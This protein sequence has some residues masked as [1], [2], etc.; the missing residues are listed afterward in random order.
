[1]YRGNVSL[2]DMGDVRTVLNTAIKAK[3]VVSKQKVRLWATEFSWD[4]KPPDPKGVPAALE[5]R[6]VSEALYRVWANGV[7]LLVWLELRDQ[8]F[9]ESF[10]QSGL[11]YA[12]PDGIASDRAK[13][14][15]RSFSFPFVALPQK[16]KGKNT[17]FVWGRTPTSK[18]A[19][20]YIERKTAGKWKRAKKIKA[21]R[22]G[23]FKL[24]I[25][26]MP[27]KTTQMR[28]HLAGGST[29]S[30]SFALKAPKKG[31]KNC[32]FGTCD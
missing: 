7:S 28:A 21:N 26:T 6:W 1:M 8:P 3:R 5:A 10:Y 4:T 27:K 18:A 23:I 24:R 12:S 2:G 14:A 9:P 32:V 11:Y 16:V 15:L 31:W 22:Y 29:L 19:T 30:N 13:P 17:V 25:K 20:V